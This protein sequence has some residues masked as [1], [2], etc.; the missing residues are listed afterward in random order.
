M[1]KLK[2]R[3]HSLEKNERRNIRKTA[4]C[5]WRKHVQGNIS[6]KKI[7]KTL[8]GGKNQIEKPMG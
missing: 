6:K 5:S 3:K 8:N 7:R 4:K 1:D 2:K